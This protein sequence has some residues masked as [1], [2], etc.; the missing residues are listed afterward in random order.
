MN[1]KVVSE[2]Q[3][4]AAKLHLK[5]ASHNLMKMAK[6]NKDKK[7]ITEITRKWMEVF[8]SSDFFERDLEMKINKSFLKLER[9]DFPVSFNTEEYSFLISWDITLLSTLLEETKLDKTSIPNEK[10][11]IGE[12][13]INKNSR[14]IK[15]ENPIMVIN[16]CV[17][18][19][20]NH[21]V[22][23]GTHRIHNSKKHEVEVSEGYLIRDKI[24]LQAM[25][26]EIM[27]DFYLMTEDLI[28]IGTYI[29]KTMIL[30]NK[31]KHLQL[32]INK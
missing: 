19:N 31:K 20:Y 10:I 26:S 12:N 21:L 30:R 6:N 17:L 1:Y 18:T 25:M 28:T 15:I 14:Y 32:N 4:N 2:S 22:I 7:L 29:Q 13:S 11:I 9:Y 5:Y 24:H 8:N 3:R 16:P 27:K 23:N